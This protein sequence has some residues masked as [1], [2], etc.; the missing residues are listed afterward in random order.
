MIPLMP[1][2]TVVPMVIDTVQSKLPYFVAHRCN[3]TQK[4]YPLAGDA[5]SVE[6]DPEQ[7]LR[8]FV[9]W[10]QLPTIDERLAAGDPA[11][12]DP[13]AVASRIRAAKQE[14]VDAGYARQDDAAGEAAE[15]LKRAREL[16]LSVLQRPAPA[17]A[18]A[19][20]TRPTARVVADSVHGWHPV[21]SESPDFGRTYGELLLSVAVP[22]QARYGAR[23]R[24]LIP[25]LKDFSGDVPVEVG[26]EQG[27]VKVLWDELPDLF[28]QTLHKLRHDV[29]DAQVNLAAMSDADSGYLASAIAD[30]GMRAQMAGMMKQF[31]MDEGDGFAA[32][33][34]MPAV[35]GGAAADLGRLQELHDS[36]VLTDDEL[37]A[38]KAR[39]E[40]EA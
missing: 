25:V 13:D 40:H 30:P 31:G 5:V 17:A 7:P 39:L 21:D 28:E 4:R 22:G 3:V 10:D 8:V 19:T 6:I 24:G 36:G 9:E 20:P 29:A 33:E 35:G 23:L 27:D 15:Q 2:E 37:A 18:T 1:F 16:A 26:D 32:L 34:A 12:T 38:E 11:F 14:L